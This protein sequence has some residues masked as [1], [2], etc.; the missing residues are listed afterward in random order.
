MSKTCISEYDIDPNWSHDFV[1]RV[2][3]AKLKPDITF[4]VSINFIPT[5]VS[6]NYPIFV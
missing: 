6:K 1:I 4:I 3:R 5:Q 2:N